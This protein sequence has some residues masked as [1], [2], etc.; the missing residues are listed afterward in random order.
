MTEPAAMDSM[1]PVVPVIPVSLLVSSA[2]RI[3]ERQLGLCW[4]SGEVSNY[5]RASSGHAYFILKDGEAQARCVLFRSK[6]QFLDFPLKDGQRIEVR[7]VPTIYETRGEFQ[8]NVETV[9]LSG[10]GALYEQFARRKARLEAD[11]WFAAARK[12]A[13]PSFPRAIGIVTSVRAAALSDVL[14]TLRLR[15][16]AVPVIVYPASVQGSGAALEI[17]AAIA[18]AN[19][20]G[21]VDVLI[22]CRGGG[23]IEDLWAFNEEP[24]AKAVYESRIPIVSGVGHETDFTICDFVADARAP[25]PTAAAAL[26]TPDGTALVAKVLQLRARARRA[27]ADAMERRMQRLD[28]A[29]R[30]L[31]HPAARLAAQRE[32]LDRLRERLVRGMRAALGRRAREVATT[33]RRI[34]QVLRAPPRQRAA[35][36]RAHARW[37][38]S[39]EKRVAVL[40]QTVANLALALRHLGPQA[41][42][43][44]G[45]SIVSTTDG[46]VVQDGSQLAAGDGIAVRFARGGADATVTR[47][48]SD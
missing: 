33:G 48:R 39:G 35:L 1:P 9:R 36:E 2:R 23:S 6:G 8:L 43:D 13:L 40:T 20:H 12:R 19:A 38:R 41:V 27:A 44:R 37:Q 4:V 29:T 15:M 21:R 5:S 25:T 30:R 18:A 24:V 47:A 34:A 22:V 3:I 46:A 42:L 17:A 16:P 7:A 26:A 28:I 31:V 10:P 32:R 11:G 14:T 45:Y